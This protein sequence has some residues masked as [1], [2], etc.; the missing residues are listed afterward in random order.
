MWIWVLRI[1][2][3]RFQWLSCLH[4]FSRNGK[5]NWSHCDSPFSS[6]LGV[7]F[8][9]LLCSWQLLPFESSPLIFSPQRL[10]LSP[11]C[12]LPPPASSLLPSLSS[13]TSEPSEH[14]WAWLTLNPLSVNFQR[15]LSCLSLVTLSKITQA[16]ILKVMPCFCLY[17]SL[18]RTSLL[19]LQDPRLNYLLLFPLPLLAN[20]ISMLTLFKIYSIIF[21]YFGVWLWACAHIPQCLFGAQRTIYRSQ[22]P[23]STMQIPGI[24]LWSSSLAAS[25][26]TRWTISPAMCTDILKTSFIL[27]YWNCLILLEHKFN[28]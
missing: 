19:P 10:S 9:S 6:L 22:L 27:D 25:T 1:P 16:A 14:Q 23:S 11:P 24:E 13:I 28:F 8:L 4:T 3:P 5:C 17:M 2:C 7:R 20:P 21:V 12:W 15:I 26:L 18:H